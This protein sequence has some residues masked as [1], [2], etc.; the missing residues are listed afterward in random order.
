MKKD[1]LDEG[2]VGRMTSSELVELI[3]NVVRS[4]LAA[5]KPSRP[6][7]ASEPAGHMDFCEE[8]EEANRSNGRT[9]Q[10]IATHLTLPNGT[11]VTLPGSLVV[12]LSGAP[13]LRE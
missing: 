11:P 1:E 5:A 6:I 3:R 10:T 4:E 9:L 8:P 13:I 7:A 2:V 12:L